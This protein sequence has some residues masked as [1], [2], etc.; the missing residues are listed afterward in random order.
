MLRPVIR[1]Q[2]VRESLA[3]PLFESLEPRV[4]MAADLSA[5]VAFRAGSF[6]D[7]LVAGDR[8]TINLTLTN[9]GN[10]IARGAIRSNFYL[11]TDDVLDAGDVLLAADVRTSVAIKPARSGT[12]PVSVVVPDLPD[13]SYC[14]IA[15]VNTTGA[16]LEDSYDNNL[17]ASLVAKDVAYV[18]GTYHGRRLTLTMIDSSSGSDVNVTFSMAGRGYGIVAGDV[19]VAGEGFDIATYG[20]DTRSDVLIRPDAGQFT[21]LSRLAVRGSV[22]EIIAPDADLIGELSISG[23]AG[24]ITLGYVGLV[25]SD[26]NATITISGRSRHWVDMDFLGVYNT[27]LSSEQSI[28]DLAVDEWIDD[29]GERDAINARTIDYLYLRGSDTVAGD[30]Q[31]DVYVATDHCHSDA[32]IGTVNV[33]GTVSGA[34]IRCDGDIRGIWVGASL[35][36]NFL[37]GVKAGVTQP[38]DLDDF[39]TRHTTRWYWFLTYWPEEATSR[40]GSFTVTGLEADPDGTFFADT[41]VAAGSIGTVDLTNVAVDNGGLRF[42]IFAAEDNDYGTPIRRV[43]L[44]DTLSGTTDTLE[45]HDLPYTDLDF[46]IRVVHD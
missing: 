4:L 23:T 40:I 19:T 36:S 27:T 30:F 9:V 43:I 21:Q 46:V 28:D 20:T 13:G 10:A 25:G 29:G 32:Y 14:V 6:A 42:G 26:T 2:S 41:N 7:G 22:D 39:F 18:F 11:S 34:T 37:A 1:K 45:H 12:Y 5:A 33:L 35:S 8:G 3:E 16:I 15:D 24:K 38:A 17:A 31:A 44:R